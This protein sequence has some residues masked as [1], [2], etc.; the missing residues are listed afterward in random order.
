MALH[1]KM[2]TAYQRLD[3]STRNSQPM[4]AQYM[5]AIVHGSP[6]PRKTLTEFDPV[7]LVTDASAVG[8]FCA[9]DL[10]AKV[11]GSEVPSATTVMA[12]HDLGSP[13]TQDQMVATSET[14]H[15]V[16]PIIASEQ[17]KHG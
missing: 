2:S 10:E 6:N 15:V 14:T 1:E 17:K 11:S 13:T 8:S 12:A 5:A 3:A 9:A 16:S 7:T 4:D